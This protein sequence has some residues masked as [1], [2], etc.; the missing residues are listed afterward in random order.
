MQAYRRHLVIDNINKVIKIEVQTSLNGHPKQW[1]Y[2]DITKGL[3]YK[4]TPRELKDDFQKA[5]GNGYRV[6]P[7]LAMAAQ[8]EGFHVLQIIDCI[9]NA[10]VVYGHRS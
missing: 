4:Y 1:E 7:F 8:N 9:E 3:W 2:D 6:E 5:I 10:Q